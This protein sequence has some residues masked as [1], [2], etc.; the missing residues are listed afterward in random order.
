MA[1]RVC[2]IGGGVIGLAT[3]YALVRDGF[4]VTVVEARDSL[5][6]GRASCR[7]RV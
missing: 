5:E 4:E 7:E 6:I 3:A 2:I 1:Q